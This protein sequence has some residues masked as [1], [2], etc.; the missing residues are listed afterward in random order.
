[1]SQKILKESAIDS[2]KFLLGCMLL[3]IRQLGVF[4]IFGFH[5]TLGLV[6]IAKFSLLK[7]FPNQPFLARCKNKESCFNYVLQLF[8][9]V[10]LLSVRDIFPM[11]I[12]S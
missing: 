9:I 11:K 3:Q 6:K 12:E 2:G 5:W 7:R 10:G 4:P 1:M 8:Q